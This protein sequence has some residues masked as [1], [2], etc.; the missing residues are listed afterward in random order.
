ME[1]LIMANREEQ[2]KQITDQISGGALS[3]RLNMFGDD[4]FSIS[5]TQFAGNAAGGM[6][7]DFIINKIIKFY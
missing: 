4:E 5:P 2:L 6:L 3:S 1:D 7:S